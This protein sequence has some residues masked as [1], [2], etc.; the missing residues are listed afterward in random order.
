MNTL[1]WSVSDGVGQLRLIRPEKRNAQNLE[2]WAELRQ[3]GYDI[4]RAGE[5][6]A[7]VLSGEGPVFSAGIDLGLLMGQA[8]GEAASLPAVE[9]VQHAFTWLRDAPFAT[10]AAVHGAALG[11][12]AQLALACDLRIFAEGTVFGLPEIDFGIFPDLGGCAWLPGLIGTAR[13]KALIFTGDRIDAAEALR[14]GIANQVVPNEGLLAAA[15]A[16]AA[17]LAAKA[18]LGIAAAK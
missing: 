3:V 10:V 1:S 14:L 7:L 8:T 12:G 15:T 13:A 16:L 2:M 17:R 11:A 9:Q 4:I 5:T 6:R 18:P